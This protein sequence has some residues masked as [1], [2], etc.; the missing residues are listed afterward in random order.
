M[1]AQAHVTPPSNPGRVATSGTPIRVAM[2]LSKGY[3]SYR[4]PAECCSAGVGGSPEYRAG[5]SSR[6]PHWQLGHCAALAGVTSNALGQAAR[7]GPTDSQDVLSR[8]R[9]WA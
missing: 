7:D 5:C 8:S 2:S 1:S 4:D 9:V 3:T 6:R